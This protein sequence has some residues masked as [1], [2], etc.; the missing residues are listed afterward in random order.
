METSNLFVGSHEVYWRMTSQPSYF[1][2]R[3]CRDLWVMILTQNF[4]NL[5]YLRVHC[6]LIRRKKPTIMFLLS[7]VTFCSSADLYSTKYLRNEQVNIGYSSNVFAPNH[8]DSSGSLMMGLQ[9]RQTREMASVNLNTPSRLRSVGKARK[10]VVVFSAPFNPNVTHMI[11]Y[12]Q[13]ENSCSWHDQL[14][15]N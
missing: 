2:Y 11:L 1:Q 13:S 9:A 6:P 8:Y 4:W 12:I 5:S 15:S 3:I 10:P 7:P 14:A